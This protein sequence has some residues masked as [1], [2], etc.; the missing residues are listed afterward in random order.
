MYFTI[1]NEYEEAIST[2]LHISWWKGS[3]WDKEALIN[4][5]HLLKGELI[6]WLHSF[7]VNL[8]RRL[9]I[10]QHVLANVSRGSIGQMK[11]LIELSSHD[12]IPLDGANIPV[13]K[14]S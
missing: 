13:P 5:S 4:F 6:K 1:E 8:Q 9:L 2:D 14:K 7:I 3:S 12:V 11:H 10:P